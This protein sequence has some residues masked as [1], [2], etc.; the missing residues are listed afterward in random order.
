L[1]FSQYIFSRNGSSDKKVQEFLEIGGRTR[2]D[3]FKRDR[4]PGS[5]KTEIKTFWTV[6]RGRMFGIHFNFVK[7][8]S[9]AGTEQ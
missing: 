9:G 5:V 4:K 1:G 8:A 6:F 7:L 3:Q 2:I